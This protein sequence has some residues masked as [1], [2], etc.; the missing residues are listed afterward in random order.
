MLILWEEDTS[1]RVSPI[2]GP[3]AMAANGKTIYSAERALAFR[4][5][6]SR[7]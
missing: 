3:I 6:T 4:P 2:G 5:T 1:A 7:T